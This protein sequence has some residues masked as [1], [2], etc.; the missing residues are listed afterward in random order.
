M[1]NHKSDDSSIEVLAPYV[2][3][4]LVTL[5]HCKNPLVFP[6][7]DQHCFSH[8]AHEARW[9]AVLDD[10][11]FL[12]PLHG[13]DLRR[14]LAD[15]E[16]YPGIAV[17]WLMFG[18]SGHKERPNGLVIENYTRCS[19]A[20]SPLIKSIVNP[21]RVCRPK[22]PHYPIYRKR[23]LAVNENKETVRLS[24]SLS[25]TARKLP[26]NHYWSKSLEDGKRKIARGYG[27]QWGIENP[28]T[29]E[30]WHKYDAVYSAANDEA[31]LRFLPALK[32]R[33]AS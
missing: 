18:S 14:T 23:D 16:H 21:R 12:F 13:S 9:I 3:T 19:P 30:L 15:Y 31:I 11:E 5:H 8:Y 6:E 25:P 28:R 29:L 33:L 17:H 26:I 27:D 4:G 24:S 2:R 10:D 32:A 1:Y 22:S 20:L 7:S